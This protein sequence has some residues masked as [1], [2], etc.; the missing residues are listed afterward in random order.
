MGGQAIKYERRSRQDVKRSEELDRDIRK[1]TDYVWSL[2]PAPIVNGRVLAEWRFVPSTHLGGDAFGYYWLDANTFVFYL[3][4]V[5]GHGVAAAMHSVTVLNVLRQ[6]ALPLVD[7]RNPAEVLSSLN[8]RFPMDSHNGCTSRCGTGCTTRVTARS[9][10]ARQDTTLRFSC[11]STS[12]KPNRSG[13][14]R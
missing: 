11:R 6:R 4:D 3:V 12:P 9:R 7:F 8:A 1:A 13:C 5:S 2:L 14:R 10:T